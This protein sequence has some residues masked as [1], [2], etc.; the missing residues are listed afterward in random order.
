MFMSAKTF[1]YYI[2]TR[3]A[4]NQVDI[5][6]NIIMSG[7]PPQYLLVF[8]LFPPTFYGLNPLFDDVLETAGVAIPPGIAGSEVENPVLAAVFEVV[9]FVADVAAVAFAALV[10]GMAAEPLVD[11][12]VAVFAAIVSVVHVAEPQASA[13]IAP[14]FDVLAHPSDVAVLVDSHERPRFPFPTVYYYASS[15]SSVEVFGWESFH[16]TK[17]VRARY[18]FCNIL[19]RQGLHHNKSLEHCDN[20]PSPCYN[21]VNDTSVLPMDATTSHSRKICQH[22]YQE[23]RIHHPYQEL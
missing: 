10:S 23:Q 13:D 1:T 17:G 5:K 2:F 4:I 16:N 12:V 21:N 18:G 22:L 6:L 8:N 7:A 9:E 15:S 3:Q 19:S 11:I 20:K 14:A